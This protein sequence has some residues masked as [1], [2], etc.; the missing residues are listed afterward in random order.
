MNFLFTDEKHHRDTDEAF[1]TISERA[2]R[3][4]KGTSIALPVISYI[5]DVRNNFKRY[6]KL[7][8]Y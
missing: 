8:I 4:S 1:R 2:S 3:L 5:Q 6:E 7:Y